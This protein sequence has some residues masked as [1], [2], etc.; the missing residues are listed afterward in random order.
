[1]SIT[2]YNVGSRKKKWVARNYGCLMLIGFL[3]CFSQSTLALD[4]PDAPDYVGDFLNRAQAYEMEIQQIQTTQGYI[5]AYAA[6]EQFLNEALDNA[7]NRL[8]EQLNDEARLALSNSQQKWLQYK[9]AAFDFIAHNWTR[10]SFGSASVISRGNY[11][12]AI[13]KERVTLLLH[14]LKNY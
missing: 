11:R 2:F 9:Q 4:N 1:M 14:Y 13:I 6:Y 5:T 3:L 12:T 10:E 8:M 7:Y